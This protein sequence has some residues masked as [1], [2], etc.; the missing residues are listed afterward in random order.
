MR[1]VAVAEDAV[2]DARGVAV[3]NSGF[4]SYVVGVFVK[5]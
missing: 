2:G 3:T 5:F 4:K 1:V